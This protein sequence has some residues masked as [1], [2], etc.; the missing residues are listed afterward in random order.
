MFVVYYTNEH[1]FLRV[2]DAAMHFVV[3]TYGLSG[4]SFSCCFMVWCQTWTCIDE[5]AQDRTESDTVIPYLT[6]LA[7]IAKIANGRHAESFR[8][9]NEFTVN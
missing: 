4:F 7:A 2:C 3:S 8:T 5:A 1:V 6:T 9:C